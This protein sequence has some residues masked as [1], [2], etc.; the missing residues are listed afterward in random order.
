MSEHTD[1]GLQRFDGEEAEYD[2]I[3]EAM[4]SLPFLASKKLIVLRNPSAIKEFVDKAEKL[5]ANLPE[6]T[7]VVIH[8]PKLDK[9]S[10][11]YKFLKKNTEYKE[12]NELDQPQLA[13]WLI[14][15]AKKIKNGQLQRADAAY[16][17]ERV[18]LNQQLLSNELNKLLAYDPTVTRATIDLLTEPTPQS[19]IFQLLDAAFAGNRQKAL[20]IYQEQ[21]VS[22][23]EPLAILAMLA[24]QLHILALILT[25]GNRSDNDIAAQAKINP[26]VV[27]KSR[28]ITA[29][30]TLPHLKQLISQLLELDISLKTTSTDPDDA[31]Q[32]FLLAV[33]KS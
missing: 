22:K 21:R 12:F 32:L 25:A 14:D 8:E 13:S 1:M 2:Q 6:T 30:L 3:R 29:K 28:Q 10:V 7:D 19:T 24:W 20:K 16:L 11:Y 33:T 4:E 15:E 5:L 9:R 23:T 17:I 31:L 18:G 26:F 27:R